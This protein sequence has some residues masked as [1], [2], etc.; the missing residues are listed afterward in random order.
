MQ[1]AL[2]TQYTIKPNQNKTFPIGTI[3]T[4]KHIFEE[5]HLPP[6]LDDLKRCGHQLSGL[7]TGLVSYKLTEDLSVSR[8]HQWMTTNPLL[9]EYLQLSDFGDDALYRCLGIIGT[10]RHLIL[11]HLLHILKNHHDVGLD[12]VFMDWTSIHFEANPSDLINYGYSRDHRPDRPQVTIG[13]AQDQRSQ[14][15]VGLSIQPGN[16]NDQTHFKKTYNQIKPGLRTGSVLVFDA[17]A[18]GNSNLDLLVSDKMKYLSRMKL[19]QSDIKQHL[20]TFHK[21]EW[22]LIVTGKQ[23]EQ[24]YGKKLVFPSRTK[25]LYFSQ[26]LYD[27]ILLNRRKHL[28]QE[29]D[30]ALSLWKTI[31]EKKRPR[32]KYRN[33]NHF[34]QTHLSYTFPLTGLSREEAIARALQLSIT[35][36]EG[37]FALASNKDFSLHEAL[38]FYREKDCVEK[39]FNS[40]KNEIHIRPTRCWTQEA[41]YGSILIAFLAQLVISMLRYKHVSLRHVS[42]KFIMQSLK[43]FAL[44]IIVG[45]N[46]VKRRVFSNFDWINS[47]IFC[48]KTPGS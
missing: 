23:D 41:I 32:Q 10:N 8:C 17:G 22:T 39:L 29:Y 2:K 34:L 48:G 15:P 37:F 20:N 27:D 11:R 28:E 44:T 9:L 35:G 26:N 7:V 33:S 25:Y 24:V 31:Q 45:K 12:M 47:L 4:V 30:E 46:G 42:T 13:L 1:T 21:D 3:Q 38:Q 6:F 43:N 5:L 36:K 16:T 18:T 14:V 40:I 19:N